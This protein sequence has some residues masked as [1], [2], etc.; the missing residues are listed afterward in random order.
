MNIDLDNVDNVVFS[1]Y[2][3]YRYKERVTKLH[4]ESQTKKN[5]FVQIGKWVN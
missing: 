5:Q 3:V 4:G 2:P 1:L